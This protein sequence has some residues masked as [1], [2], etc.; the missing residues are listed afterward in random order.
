MNI[1]PQAIRCSMLGVSSS[2]RV[3]FR[4]SPPNPS[5]SGGHADVLSYIGMVR[6]LRGL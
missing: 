5:L 2:K 1:R 6:G 4:L 3:T